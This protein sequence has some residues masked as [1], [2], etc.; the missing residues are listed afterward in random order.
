M[1]DIIDVHELQSFVQCDG[2]II[3]EASIGRKFIILFIIQVNP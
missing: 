1:H 2:T 3:M